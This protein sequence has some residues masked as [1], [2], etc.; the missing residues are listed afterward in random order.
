[1]L[2]IMR[3]AI[4]IPDPVYQEAEE[5]A[6]RVGVSR[7]EL[8]AMAIAQFVAAHRAEAVT[9]AFNEVYAG[10]DSTVDP[11]LSQLQRL[12]LPNEEW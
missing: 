9:T 8:Y 1:M 2:S 7:S 3:T 6:K 10:A 11:V 4:S 5:L 12:H